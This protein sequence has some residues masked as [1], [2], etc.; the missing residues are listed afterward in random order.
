ML[1]GWKDSLI[2][3]ELFLKSAPWINMLVEPGKDA[4]CAARWV[5][6]CA[7]IRTA[8]LQEGIPVLCWDNMP[9]SPTCWNINSSMDDDHFSGSF[10]NGIVMANARQD[11]LLGRNTDKRS[12]ISLVHHIQLFTIAGK[13]M[14]PF[15]IES[16]G[17]VAPRGSPWKGHSSRERCGVGPARVVWVPR[18]AAEAAVLG[19]FVV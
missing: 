3:T 12:G 5:A 14:L 11:F 13:S 2:A 15:N 7:T 8:L 16:C 10:L 17:Q 4:E 6:V 1:E 19:G 18:L 9:A